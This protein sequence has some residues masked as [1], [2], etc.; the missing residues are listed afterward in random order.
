VLDQTWSTTD[1]TY[2]PSPLLHAN[3][4][5]SGDTN[6]LR[7]HPTSIVWW[8]SL[9]ECQHVAIMGTDC[10]DIIFV[11]LTT[12]LQVGITF[13]RATISLLHICQDNS[14]DSVFLLVSW[15]LIHIDLFYL[16]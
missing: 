6:I 13:V 5:N 8:Q 11:S 7:S 4:S 12:G 16:I 9:L 15:C 1:L 2:I 3:P 10:G 14:L